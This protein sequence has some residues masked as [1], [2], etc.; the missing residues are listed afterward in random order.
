MRNMVKNNEGFADQNEAL[1]PLKNFYALVPSI[2]ICYIDHLVNGREKTKKKPY[3][4]GFISDDGFALG[5]VFL[6]RV[7]GVQDDFNSL[8][9]FTSM[10]AKLARDEKNAEEKK[11]EL[12]IKSASGYEDVNFEEEF[13]LKRLDMLKREYQMLNFCITASSILFKEI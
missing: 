5:V 9:W 6:L 12:K 3:T 10:Q 4:D 11:K 7:L 1:L 13:S 8:N 2:S